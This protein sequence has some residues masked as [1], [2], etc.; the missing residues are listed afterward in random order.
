MFRGAQTAF[1]TTILVPSLPAGLC[2]TCSTLTVTLPLAP[3]GNPGQTHSGSRLCSGTLWCARSR[4]YLAVVIAGIA[5]SL[6][7]SSWQALFAIQLIS[8]GTQRMLMDIQCGSAAPTRT[9]SNSVF[10]GIEQHLRPLI[11]RPAPLPFRRYGTWQFSGGSRMGLLIL[12]AGVLPP[13]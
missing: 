12:A 2:F 5:P 6:V 9:S 10:V 7:S 1:K 11:L 3:N 13:Q 4:L 8:T